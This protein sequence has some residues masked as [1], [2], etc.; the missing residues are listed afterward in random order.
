[1]LQLR[2]PGVLF[3]V[4]VAKKSDPQAR[5]FVGTISWFGT[6]R[7]HGRKSPEGRTLQFDVSDQ[8]QELGNIANASGLTVTIEATQGRVP[9]DPKQAEVMQT[10]AAKAFRPQAKMQIGSIELE[11]TS[12][13]A[14]SEKPQ[15]P[16]PVYVSD[17][18][19]GSRNC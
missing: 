5:K 11:R 6:F 2:P 10:A 4:Y 1:M 19:S 17:S 18:R 9:T 15:R 13:S 16:A 12:F 7:H 14:A 8:L 3:N